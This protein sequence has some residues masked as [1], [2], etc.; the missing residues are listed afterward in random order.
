MIAALYMIK[1]VQTARHER[2]FFS[3]RRILVLAACG[4]RRLSVQPS[5]NRQV[6]CFRTL[7]P[8]ICSGLARKVAGG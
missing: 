6:F 7:R 8:V 2:D 5:M 3:N 1:D 4:L